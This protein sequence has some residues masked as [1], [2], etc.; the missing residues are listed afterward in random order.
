MRPTRA[1]AAVALVLVCTATP[2]RA[3][4]RVVDDGAGAAQ[5]AAHDLE[6]V[7]W[8]YREEALVVTARLA[9]VR[10]TGVVLTSRS[11][12]EGEGY[13]V[14]ARTWWRAGKKRDRLWIWFNTVTRTRIDCPGLRS[15]WRVGDDGLI[16]LVVP[17]DCVFDGWAMDDFRVSTS[18]LGSTDVLDLVASG[19]PLTSA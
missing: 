4:T 5:S 6:R 3:D 1:A 17:N 7:T 19:A 11:A 10:R 16:R 12:H 15:R 2:A 13:E 14:V 18:A 8:D 9:T